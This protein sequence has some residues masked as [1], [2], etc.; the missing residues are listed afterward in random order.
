MVIPDDMDVI[1]AGIHQSTLDQ[2]R[3][4]LLIVIQNLIDV[5]AVFVASAGNEGDQRYNPMSPDRPNALYPA[6]FVYNGLSPEQM[7][8]MIPVGAVDSN[9]MPTTYSCY[10]GPNGVATYGGKLPDVNTDVGKNSAGMTT[11]Q[12]HDGVI[13]LYSSLNYPAL[14]LDDPEAEYPAPNSRGWA[15]WIGTSFATPIVSAVAARA[16]ELRLRTPASPLAQPVPNIVSG[17]VSGNVTWDRLDTNTI[18]SVIGTSTQGGMIH[19]VQCK[20]EEHHH[21][22]GHHEHGEEEH[23]E[24]EVN[25]TNVYLV[26]TDAD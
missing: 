10:P 17:A 26:E 9:G 11:V 8:G 24:V 18:P 20:G 25:V 1:N 5:G 4:N 14:S 12:I 21:H 2:A 15:Y 23:E 22:H 6:A 3:S 13:G 7:H 16:L 19:A